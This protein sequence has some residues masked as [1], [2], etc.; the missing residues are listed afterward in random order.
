MK[1]IKLFL[2]GIL[3]N[4]DNF[5]DSFKEKYFDKINDDNNNIW[6]DNNGDIFIVKP[7]VDKAL[8]DIPF[9]KGK[10]KT[11]WVRDC[12]VFDSA[13]IYRLHDVRDNS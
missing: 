12:D 11:C 4:N 1:K 7:K 3:L 5:M 13:T 2:I 9:K 8:I 10:L 6:M